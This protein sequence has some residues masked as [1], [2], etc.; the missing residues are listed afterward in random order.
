MDTLTIKERSYRMHLI[1]SKDTQPELTVRRL[2]YSMGYRYR[3]HSTKLPGKPDIVFSG[4]RKA[5]FV[6]GCFW[7]QHEGCRN[8]RI[9][10][11]RLRYWVPKLQRNKQR[12]ETNQKTLKAQGWRVLL[13]WECQ[14]KKPGPMAVRIK[15]FLKPSEKRPV[16]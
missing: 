4:Q 9:P 12:D 10:K 3:L 1:R 15:R 13:I 11:S 5:I 16:R 7:H 14:T 6:H 8:S 2:V